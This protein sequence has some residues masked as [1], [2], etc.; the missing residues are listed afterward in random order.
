MS[1]DVKIIAEM[2]EEIEYLRKEIEELTEE[3]EHLEEK[4]T[5]LEEVIEDCECGSLYRQQVEA[6]YLRGVKISDGR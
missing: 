5:E 3:N 4:V 2:R 1:K 6:T